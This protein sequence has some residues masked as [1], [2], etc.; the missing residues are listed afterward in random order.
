M[1][2]DLPCLLLMALDSH[3]PWVWCQNW[4]AEKQNAI[5]DMYIH[6][7]LLLGEKTSRKA[8]HVHISYINWFTTADGMPDTMYYLIMF[9][10]ILRYKLSLSFMVRE[11]ETQMKDANFLRSP[12]WE[13]GFKY[14]CVWPQNP[15][16]IP[17]N[18]YCTLCNRKKWGPRIGWFR[19]LWQE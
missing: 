18:I 14:R 8:I 19:L 13:T 3:S 11:N 16:V 7:Y 5:T 17:P 12:R 6:F 4:E 1:F 9:Y 15:C 2:S 10:N